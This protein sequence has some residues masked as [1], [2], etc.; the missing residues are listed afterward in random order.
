MGPEHIPVDVLR[1]PKPIT[2]DFTRNGDSYKSFYVGPELAK[3]SPLFTDHNRVQV[4]ATCNSDTVAAS[5]CYL[6]NR[7]HKRITVNGI[8]KKPNHASSN[9]GLLK[10]YYV[11]S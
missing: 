8:F 2:L 4:L 1:N 6:Y 5:N 9:A 11:L 3:K 7:I 10:E